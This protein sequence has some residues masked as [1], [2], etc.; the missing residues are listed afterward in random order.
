MLRYKFI[1]ITD[2]KTDCDLCGKMELKKTIVLLDSVTDQY[3]FFGSDCASRALGW[4]VKETKKTARDSD[5]EYRAR[6]RS[7]F[8]EQPELTERDEYIKKFYADGG[9]FPDLDFDKETNLEE[10]ARARALKKFP[11][12]KPTDLI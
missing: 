3:V 11:F 4:G 7:F 6:A 2:E 8:L 5:R 9:K 12:C 1:A 10:T